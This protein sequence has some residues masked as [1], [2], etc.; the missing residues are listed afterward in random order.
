M[1]KP[2]FFRI[3]HGADNYEELLDHTKI[4]FV[5]TSF[6][7]VGEK[8]PLDPWRAS[9]EITLEGGIV[10]NIYL[11]SKGYDWFCKLIGAEPEKK[12]KE[13]GEKPTG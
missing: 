11:S 7:Y 10:K 8:N 13:H 6:M 9:V 4:I 2:R 12:E 1:A 3:S 5:Q